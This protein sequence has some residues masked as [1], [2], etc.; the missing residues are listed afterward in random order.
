MEVEKQTPVLDPP[1]PSTPIHPPSE[2]SI[3][4]DS[5]V[6]DS[7][8]V[9]DNA[10]APHETP[11]IKD[12][13]NVV[14]TGITEN[15]PVFEATPSEDLVHAVVPLKDEPPA[16]KKLMIGKALWDY[17]AIEDNELSFKAGDNI[18]IIEL[19]N[20]DWYEGRLGE[21]VDNTTETPNNSTSYP[22]EHLK[23]TE[24]MVPLDSPPL[25]QIVPDAVHVLEQEES[26]NPFADNEEEDEEESYVEVNVPDG[27]EGGNLDMADGVSDVS[28]GNDI[29][30]PL[31]AKLEGTVEEDAVE[32]PDVVAQEALYVP[33]E[34]EASVE[35]PPEE[36]FLTRPW[37]WAKDDEGQIYYWNED[38]G[39]RTWDPPPGYG[40]PIG[41]DTEY[42][43]GHEKQ[44]SNESAAISFSTTAPKGDDET[45]SLSLAGLDL[46]LSLVDPIPSDLV[47]KEGPVRRK[48]KRED[49]MREPRIT[50]TWKSMYAMVCVGFIV[51]LKDAP[52][53]SRAVGKDTTSKKNAFMITLDNGTGRQWLIA[54][55]SDAS[56]WIDV[57]R[58]CSRD[59]I[60]LAEYEN[61]VSRMF[62]RSKSEPDLLSIPIIGAKAR[63]ST[64][65]GKEKDTIATVT[66][67][68][69]SKSQVRSKL[70]AF[71]SKKTTNPKGKDKG[72][73][74]AEVVTNTVFG[75]DLASEVE[76]RKVPEVVEVCCAEVERRGLLSQ[77][78]YR[79]SGNTTTI[80]KL[81]ASFN[82][83][84][85]VKLDSEDTDINVVAGLLKLY[86]R[87]LPNPLIPFEFYEPIIKAA[88]IDDYNERLIQFKNLIQ[89][90]P[91]PTTTFLNS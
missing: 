24:A 46:N 38:T 1:I 48:L 21:S 57:L 33:L 42:R 89:A 22:D 36:G 40:T 47:R 62:S 63:R 53:K 43:R 80:Q 4:L 60:T 14:N 55:D 13:D 65:A 58:S 69:R 67:Q 37:R 86:F 71:F 49:D 23:E 28:Y 51:F 32:A 52:A 19:C 25:D 83:Y 27:E 78:I 91:H 90:L 79:L 12:E 39:E 44:L 61:A 34:G 72:I 82:A 68:E 7:S 88:K 81:R 6:T 30:Q 54:P 9:A 74:E 29:S 75:G 15:L 41:S 66:D 45:A 56:Q 20:D 35:P 11:I 50:A 84:E 3:V 70:T 16:G 73:P 85:S 2:A 87:E 17:T 59:R 77:G 18:E 8:E 64:T 76:G 26:E 10:G 5:V 31:V